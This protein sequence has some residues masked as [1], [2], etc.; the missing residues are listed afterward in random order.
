[1][2]LGRGGEFESGGQV[3]AAA[4][5]RNYREAGA[6]HIRLEPRLEP[7]LQPG[8]RLRASEVRA[9]AG[10]DLHPTG[11]ASE[12]VFARRGGDRLLVHGRGNP[13]SRDRTDIDAV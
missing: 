7:R 5:G 3:A 13:E 1:M 12:Q 6:K 9:E 8:L 2:T 10:E 4:L 11:G